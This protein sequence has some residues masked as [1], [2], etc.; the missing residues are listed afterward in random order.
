M[1]EIILKIGWIYNELEN[2]I[3]TLNGVIQVKLNTD[4]D[5][6]YIKYDSTI[7]SIKVLVLEVKLF[8]NSVNTPLIKKFNKLSNKKLIDTT[9]VFGDL[10]CEYC[11][12][13]KIEDLILIDGIE[14]VSVDFDNIN[15]FNVD[16]KIKYDENKITKKEIKEYNKN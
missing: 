3:L 2:Y 9:L 8:V 6:L 10:F 14:M 4:T 5:E 1:S 15:Y 16:I 12:K 11:V 7:I 13:G